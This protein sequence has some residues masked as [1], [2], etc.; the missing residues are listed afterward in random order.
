MDCPYCGKA[1]ERFLAPL[2][3]FILEPTNEMVE[4]WWCPSCNE[5]TGTIT[6]RRLP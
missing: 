4:A 5:E 1:M 6:W 2:A 3:E